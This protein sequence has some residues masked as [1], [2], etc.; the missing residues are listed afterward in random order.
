MEILYALF[1]IGIA[2]LFFAFC[3]GIEVLALYFAYGKNWRKHT[4]FY[5]SIQ[6]RKLKKKGKANVYECEVF[7]TMTD[8]ELFTRELITVTANNEM[9]AREK[10]YQEYAKKNNYPKDGFSVGKIQL[11]KKSQK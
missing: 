7:V 10:A 3:Y 4:L 11:L 5:K 8:S 6:A 2:V 9:L 1:W